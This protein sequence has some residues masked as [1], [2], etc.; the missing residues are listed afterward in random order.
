MV[1]VISDLVMVKPITEE[2]LGLIVRPE[3]A[4]RPAPQR[5]VVVAVGPGRRSKRGKL[6]PLGVKI[7]DY[8]VVE[9]YR[10]TDISV[11]GQRLRILREHE[12]LAVL[13][14]NE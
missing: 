4:K 10:G 8:V 5:G 2:D 13:E 12:I 11:D 6:V 7:G 14:G 1:K 9:K 3:N